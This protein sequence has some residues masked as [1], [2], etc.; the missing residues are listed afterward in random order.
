MSKVNKTRKCP[1]VQAVTEA[2]PANLPAVRNAQGG[3][4]HGQ[5]LRDPQR[6]RLLRRRGFSL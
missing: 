2:D 4:L 3:R 5:V 1:S 6:R